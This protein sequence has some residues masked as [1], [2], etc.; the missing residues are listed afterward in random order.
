MTNIESPD[1]RGRK[2]LPPERVYEGSQL[3]TDDVADLE[4]WVID[5]NSSQGGVTLKRLKERS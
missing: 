4:R 1:K 5:L 2:T 3:S